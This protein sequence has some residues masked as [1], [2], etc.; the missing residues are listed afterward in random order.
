[1]TK[2]EFRERYGDAPIKRDLMLLLPKA[3]D[4]V[5]RVCANTP[6]SYSVLL[7]AISCYSTFDQ[8]YSICHCSA[9]LTKST[10]ILWH[11]FIA[12]SVI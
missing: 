7:V 12:T 8:Q 2:D 10:L 5:K 4:P 9:L 3:D 6:Y 1:M 11:T